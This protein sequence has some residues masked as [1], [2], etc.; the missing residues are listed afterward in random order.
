MM[1][2]ERPLLS[3]EDPD[4]CK[5]SLSQEIL[6]QTIGLKHGV[7]IIHKVPC[8]EVHIGRYDWAPREWRKRT[9][10]RS[11]LSRPWTVLVLERVWNSNDKWQREDYMYILSGLVDM[12]VLRFDRFLITQHITR[13]FSWLLFSTGVTKSMIKR[14]A[15]RAL[16]QKLDSRLS[17]CSNG[18][19][20]RAWEQGYY[21]PS[22][23]CTR[24][25][26]LLRSTSCL[27]SHSITTPTVL[28]NKAT[29]RLTNLRTTNR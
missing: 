20:G 17:S 5:Q 7:E 6:P 8:N 22:W 14:H 4:P 1:K 15:S 2:Y 12:S 23:H 21:S 11:G 13:I 27:V 16:S 25:A 3:C 26:Y 28:D 10:I 19:L 29:A 18:K 9:V 24:W